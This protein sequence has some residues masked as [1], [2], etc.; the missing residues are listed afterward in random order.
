MPQTNKANIKGEASIRIIMGPCYYL[1]NNGSSTLTMRRG[2]SLMG[3][4]KVTWR[5]VGEGEEQN[6]NKER[7]VKFTSSSDLIVMNNA[8]MTL[9]KAVEDPPWGE[10]A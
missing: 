6:L 2:T 9:H 1:V 5:K 8:L 10:G 3:F 4:G 7:A